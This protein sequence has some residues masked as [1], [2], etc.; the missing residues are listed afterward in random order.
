MWH[1]HTQQLVAKTDIHVS[2]GDYLRCSSSRIRRSASSCAITSPSRPRRSAQSL[3]SG[4][5]DRYDRSQHDSKVA[6]AGYEV[7][8][9]RTCLLP[10]R[11]PGG[12]RARKLCTP[13]SQSSSR[14]QQGFEEAPGMAGRPTGALCVENL[15]WDPGHRLLVEVGLAL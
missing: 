11:G 2:R 4:C 12:A 10:M 1:A 14:I 9:S 7:Y 3:P 5:G 13:E 15:G 6:A 8:T